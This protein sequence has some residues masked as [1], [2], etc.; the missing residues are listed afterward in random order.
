MR[1]TLWDILAWGESCQAQVAF[2]ICISKTQAAGLSPGMS[3]THMY[4]HVCAYVC[5]YI[6]TNIYIH[7]HTHTHTHIHI[8][9]CIH[10]Y[11]QLRQLL[12]SRTTLMVLVLLRVCRNLEGSEEPD[13]TTDNPEENAE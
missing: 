11:V 3:L 8:H 1:M 10:T 6:Y 5:T 4:M 2:A 7:T 12:G 9:A 13:D